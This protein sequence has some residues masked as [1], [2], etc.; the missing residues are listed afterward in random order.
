MI[1]YDW[2]CRNTHEFEEFSSSDCK[3]L[4]CPEC[5]A[6]AIRLVSAARTVLEGLSGDFPGAAM[7]WEKAHQANKYKD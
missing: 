5:G 1:L 4:A 3:E 6:T 2:K 7:K